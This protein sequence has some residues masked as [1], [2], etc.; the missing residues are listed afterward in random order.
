MLREHNMLPGPGGAGQVQQLAD[1][2]RDVMET[3]MYEE[4]AERLA[5]TKC[6]RSAF[7]E[8]GRMNPDSF[9]LTK[10]VFVIENAYLDNRLNLSE[11]EQAIR[12]R[13]DEVMQIVRRANLSPKN[14]LAINYAIQQLYEHGNSYEDSRTHRIVAVP[15]F[16]YDFEDFEGAKDYTKMFASKMLATGSGQCHSMP[17]VYLMLAEQLKTKAWLSLAPQHSFI[18]FMDN[19]GRLMNFETTNGNLVSS[20]WL[21]ESGYINGKALRNKTYLDTLSQRS[22][23]ARC[24]ADLLLGYLH[25]FGYDDFSFAI[26]QRILQID[27]SNLT[28][29]IVDANVK[30]E[31][32][33]QQIKKAGRPTSAD[34]P[35]FPAAYR[36]YLAMQEAVSRVENLGYQN[37]PAE[38]Y[39]AW[40]QSL[41]NEKGKQASQALRDR[42]RSQVQ[43]LRQIH[44]TLQYRKN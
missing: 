41:G 7:T 31:V 13:A 23:Y 20:S 37:M 18:Q 4:E 12:E 29:L 39:Q 33:M 36:A 2:E 27:P 43:A 1:M 40:L 35:K 25:K 5:R 22:L 21:A 42:I 24:L 32:A 8:L 3:S 9:S 28:A 19:K 11:L 38:A 44:S 10:A 16:K 15:A 17:L 14:S 30:T 34:L 26:S 6:Y